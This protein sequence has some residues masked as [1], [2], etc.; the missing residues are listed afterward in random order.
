MT[1]N[2]DGLTVR[3][4]TMPENGINVEEIAF[5][6]HDYGD[7]MLMIKV[8]DEYLVD[9]WDDGLRECS[10]DQVKEVIK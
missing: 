3:M 4:K 1:T 9:E 8:H 6:L 5:V 2:Y 7:G 10:V